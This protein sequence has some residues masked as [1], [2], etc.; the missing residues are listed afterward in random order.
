MEVGGRFMVAALLSCGQCGRFF[1]E[2]AA[3]R[4]DLNV[5]LENGLR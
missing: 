2:N 3:D 1:V 4:P 5:A